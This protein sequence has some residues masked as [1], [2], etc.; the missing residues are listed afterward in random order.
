MRYSNSATRGVRPLE[1]AGGPAHAVKLRASGGRA[2]R[3]PT[4]TERYYSDPANLARAEVRP[5]HAW[6]GEGGADV[7]LP[8]GWLV[9]GTVFR[10]ADR[11]VI[12]WLRQTPAD[13]WQTYNIRAID[14]VGVEIG[15][16]RRFGTGAFVLVDY[17]AL[18]LDAPG[19]DPV[20]EVR[21]RLRP[22]L[23]GGCRLG[24]PA[25]ARSRGP[26]PRVPSGERDRP[27]QRT[28]CCS[29]CASAGGCHR[30]WMCTS[31]GRI[32][33][34]RSYTEVAGVPMPGAAMMV[35]LA[36]GR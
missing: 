23:V 7:V 34:D 14:T 25:V 33:L 5:E 19:G 11:D 6:S 36:I 4:F 8:G 3:V 9:Q 21:A 31:T 16:R 28:T 22:A 1:S 12:D 30:C 18:D 24:R 15:V 17:T 13:R 2:F 32:C 20:V 26:P 27:A 10:R 29:T 35:S